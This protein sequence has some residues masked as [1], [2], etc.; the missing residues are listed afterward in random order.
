MI[1]HLKLWNYWYGSVSTTPPKNFFLDFE[2]FLGR[3]T[4]CFPLVASMLV[5]PLMGPIL[6]GMDEWHFALNFIFF[7][8]NT[9]F[10]G[11]FFCALFRT[12]DCSSIQRSSPFLVRQ[13]FSFIIPLSV[14]FFTKLRTTSWKFKTLHICYFKKMLWFRLSLS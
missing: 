3:K 10:M 5:S 9:V 7:Y 6:A 12:L 1:Y 11:R 14:L 2:L 4:I 8:T 13:P